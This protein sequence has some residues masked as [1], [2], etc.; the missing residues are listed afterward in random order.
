M[1]YVCYGT[2]RGQKGY[3]RGVEKWPSTCYSSK[4]TKFSS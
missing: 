3:H 1:L 2:L 4:E